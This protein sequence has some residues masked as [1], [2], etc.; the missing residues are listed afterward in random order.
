MD[1]GTN[2][3]VENPVVEDKELTEATPELTKCTTVPVVIVEQV[4]SV[5]G[6]SQNGGAGST[7]DKGKK[8]KKT[9]SL[10]ARI[11]RY[12]IKKISKHHVKEVEVNFDSDN[13]S[14]ESSGEDNTNTQL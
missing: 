6:D 14:Q 7:G 10:K 8:K 5:N 2:L 3:I 9:M 13:S 4:D 12:T 1:L 11:K